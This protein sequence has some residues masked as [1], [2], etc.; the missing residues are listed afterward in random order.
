M[1]A[2][3]LPGAEIAMFFIVSG[4]SFR[5]WVLKSMAIRFSHTRTTIIH[6]FYFLN[7]TA[8]VISFAAEYCHT[9]CFLDKLFLEKQS[10]FNDGV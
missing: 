9:Q 2:L 5:I 4:Y 3:D 1:S 6:S 7:E 10:S 8:P